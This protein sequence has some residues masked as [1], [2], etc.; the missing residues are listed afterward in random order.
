MGE[1]RGFAKGYVVRF[2]IGFQK[3]I[4][5][6]MVS[7][8]TRALQL[9]FGEEGLAFAE[10]LAKANDLETLCLVQRSLLDVAT[11]DELRKLIEAQE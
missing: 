10:E 3:G 2:L 8:L 5:F 7:T 1:E 4:Q 9:K 6:G 11:L